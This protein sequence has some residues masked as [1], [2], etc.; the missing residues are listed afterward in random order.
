MDQNQEGNIND[1][2]QQPAVPNL[3]I[4]ALMGEVRRMMRAE[5]EPIHDRLDRVEEG[6]QRGQPQNLPYMH[7]RERVQPRGVR[8]E[9]EGY[10]GAGFDEEE[11]RDSVVSHRRYG[12]RGREL[13]IGKIIIWVV[14][15]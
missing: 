3:Q 15:R 14:L 9:E 4:Q 8:D 6:T 13:G 2:V 12:G 5:L 11:D 10:Y 1:E 7:R